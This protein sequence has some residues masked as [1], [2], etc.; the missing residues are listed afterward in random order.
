MSLLEAMAH[1]APVVATAVG[2]IPEAVRDGVEGVLVAP[3]D[4]GALAAAVLG[5]LADPDAR[6]RLGAAGR[7]RVRTEFSSTRM[8]A[9]LE[10]LYEKLAAHEAR[11]PGRRERFDEKIG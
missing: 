11:R 1:G 6:M 8:I 5:L 10:D 9:T 4:P 3:G 7:E 2:G